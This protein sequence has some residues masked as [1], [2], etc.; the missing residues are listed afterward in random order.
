MNWDQIA[1]EW[2]NMKGR[3]REQ[4]GELTDDDMDRIG[5]KKDQLVGTIQ[6]KYGLAKEEAERQVDEFARKA[7]PKA[8]SRAGA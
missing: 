3:I 2:K 4:W 1:G 5:G 7:E 8:G 6:S